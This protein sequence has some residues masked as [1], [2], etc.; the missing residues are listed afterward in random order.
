[1]PKLFI[2]HGGLNSVIEAVK[3]GVPLLLFPFFGD[4][5]NN[6]EAMAA[7]GVAKVLDIRSKTLEKELAEALNEIFANYSMYKQKTEELSN[8][9]NSID[10]AKEFLD[11]FRQLRKTL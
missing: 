10:V 9:L 3:F 6:A 7:R 1:M 5:Y 8:K 4:Q 11:A 2:T